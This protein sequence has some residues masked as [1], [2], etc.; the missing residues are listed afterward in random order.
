M[1]VAERLREERARAG[2]T[3]EEVAAIGGVKKLTQISY[4]KGRSAPDTDYLLAVAAAGIDAGY[5]LLGRRSAASDMAVHESPPAPYGQLDPAV[6]RAAI[7]ELGGWLEQQKLRLDP[8][9]FAEAVMSLCA[10]ASTP[11]EVTKKA[12]ALMNVVK[13]QLVA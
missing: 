1:S 7:R 6:V 4:E 3:Q 10:I 2:L 8:D 11:S 13:L 5:V 12:P 9:A